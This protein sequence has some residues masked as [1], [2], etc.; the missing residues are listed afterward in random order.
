VRAQPKGLPK[1]LAGIRVVDFTWVRAGPWAARWL[2]AFGADVIK[3]E[4][5]ENLDTLR[6]NRFTVPPGVQPGP[7][8]TGQFADTNAN[9]RGIT[10]NVR[11]PK[12]LA[13][14]KELIAV[15][16]VVIENFSSRVMQRWGLGYEEMKKL[17][18]DIVYVSMAGFGQTGRHHSYSTMGPS[19]QALSGLTV[20]SGLPGEPPAGWGWSYLDDT[21]GMFGAMCALTGLKHRSATGQGQHVDLSQMITGITL[22]GSAFLDRTV[23][24][25]ESRREGYPP[26]NRTV[27]PG[28]PVMNNYRGPTVAPHNAYRTK[29]G[30][31]NDWCVIACFSDEEWD[32]LVSVMENPAWAGDSRF[33]TLKGRIEHQ[34]EMDRQIE[35]WTLT[36]GKYEVMEKCQASR[37]RAMPVQSSEDR[38]E[39]DPQLRFRGMYSVLPHPMLGQWKFQNAPFQL[40]KSP[41]EVVRPPPMIGQHNREIFEDLLGVPVGEIVEAYHDGTFWP[42]EMPKYSYIEESLP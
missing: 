4:W 33:D 18:P 26:G 39:H 41:A 16:D 14:I 9:K 11:T 40:T 35:A 5:P 25:R 3:V 30:G 36:L 1:P 6:Q 38:V 28:A 21:G 34:E 23:N 24:G 22:N 7:N 29:G 31:Y 32:S 27:W 8:S 2:G 19:A 37:V 15:S 10:I 13:M 20:L 42:P 17:R 12:G